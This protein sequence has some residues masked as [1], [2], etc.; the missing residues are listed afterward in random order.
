VR[1]FSSASE[2]VK[3]KDCTYATATSPVLF[4]GLGLNRDYSAE[5]VGFEP[6]VA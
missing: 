4:A 3:P 6:T 5:E 2:T 1:P